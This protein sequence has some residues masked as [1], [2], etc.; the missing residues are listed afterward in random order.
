VSVLIDDKT[1]RGLLLIV[2]SEELNFRRQT[3]TN[4]VATNMFI[5][6]SFAEEC[7]VKYVH[8]I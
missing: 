4:S 5:I 7:F 8:A 2:I 3:T 1:Q 6:C